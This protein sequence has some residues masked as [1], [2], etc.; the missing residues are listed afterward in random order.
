MFHKEPKFESIAISWQYFQILAS[1]NWQLSV[2][3][4]ILFYLLIGNIK[5][6]YLS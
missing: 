3:Q 6:K 4:A 5:G 1:D 2:T